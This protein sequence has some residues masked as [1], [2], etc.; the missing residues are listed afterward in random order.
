[1]LEAHR[2]EHPGKDSSGWANFLLEWLLGDSGK[3]W[4]V[5]REVEMTELLC[6][7]TEKN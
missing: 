7:T 3:Q 1:M 6:L 4:C 5:L 2:I